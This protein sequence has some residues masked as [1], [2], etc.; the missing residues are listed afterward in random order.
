MSMVK[1]ILL[2]TGLSLFS[3]AA[4]PAQAASP[5]IEVE[6]GMFGGTLY[7]LS[8]ALSEV[9]KTQHPDIK[10]VPVETTGNA[11]GIIK[12]SASPAD[13]LVAG[14]AIPLQ[15]AIQG[16]SPFPKKF[17]KFR[18]VAGA[19]VHAETLITLD[20]NIRTLAD[21][22][23]KRIGLGPQPSMQGR[24]MWS[25]MR[26]STHRSLGTSTYFFVRSGF[27]LSFFV[28]ISLQ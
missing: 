16:V 26:D 8:Y 12:A 11:A 17:E 6:A 1:N 14:S 15:E 5:T 13:R 9:F 20:P 7:N 23:G 10:L 2:A 22:S 25:I 28:Q 24:T 3:A 21:L 4:I 27:G 19:C 18:F